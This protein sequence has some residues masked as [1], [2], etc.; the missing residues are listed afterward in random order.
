MEELQD[1]DQDTGIYLAYDQLVGRR[2]RLTG[3]CE[4]RGQDP[5]G[6]VA[7]HA[8]HAIRSLFC[9]NLK[10]LLMFLS[11]ILLRSANTFANSLAGRVWTQCSLEPGSVQERWQGDPGSSHSEDG[12]VRVPSIAFHR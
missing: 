8:A 11:C 10:M 1:V 6:R 7:R 5:G 2:K 4:A 12:V 9:N 3:D